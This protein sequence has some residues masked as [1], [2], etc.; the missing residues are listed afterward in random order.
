MK[1]IS[2]QGKQ[3]SKNIALFCSFFCLYDSCIIVNMHVI[4]KVGEIYKKTHYSF[5]KVIIGYK[6][7]RKLEVKLRGTR[8]KYKLI[9][10]M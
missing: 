6:E 5:K 10:T 8:L 3:S 2:V 9:L 1:H 4:L 7:G